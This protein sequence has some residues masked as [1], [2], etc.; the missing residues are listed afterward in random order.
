MI[1]FSEEKILLLHL[2]MGEATEGSIGVRDEKLLESALEST[3]S[4]FGDVEFYPSN[5]WNRSLNIERKKTLKFGHNQKVQVSVFF[6]N[7]L[8]HFRDEKTAI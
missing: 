8:M 6:Y 3:F 2:W 4:G 5:C 1:R 7:N